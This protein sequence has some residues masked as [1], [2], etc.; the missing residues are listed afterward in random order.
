ML[1]VLMTLG[2]LVATVGPIAA[3][4]GAGPASAGVVP[5]SCATSITCARRQSTHPWKMAQMPKGGRVGSSSCVANCEDANL[6]DVMSC[7][8][9][10]GLGPRLAQLA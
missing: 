6:R 1:R 7:Y 3:E 4:I 10:G 5:S 8:Y 2:L 9:E